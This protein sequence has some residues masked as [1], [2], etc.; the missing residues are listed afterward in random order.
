[1]YTGNP[2][3]RCIAK[4]CTY[5]YKT[6]MYTGNP[7]TRPILHIIQSTV[8]SVHCKCTKYWIYLTRTYVSQL[9]HYK[10]QK[11]D[12]AKKYKCCC[13]R[14]NEKLNKVFNAQQ[15]IAF[16]D[17]NLFLVFLWPPPRRNR[18]KKNPFRGRILRI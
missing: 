8:Y 1:M 6:K 10:L 3:S 9:C 11:T 18:V 4:S 16:I 13:K 15:K 14:M 2:D 17:S 12:S 7:D 5:K